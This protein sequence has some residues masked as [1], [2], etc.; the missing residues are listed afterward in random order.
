MQP[1]L[2]T[3]IKKHFTKLSLDTLNTLFA[4]KIAGIGSRKIAEELLGSKTK[5][6]TINYL[7]N[8]ILQ[9]R[10]YFWSINEYKK[11]S[12]RSQH[13]SN[14]PKILVLDIETAPILGCVWSLW[15]NNL[16][17]NQVKSDWFIMSFAAKW[18]GE[19]EESTIY[20]DVR[21]HIKDE[22]DSMLLETLWELL[23][24]ADF[25]LTQNGVKFDDKK[26]KARFVLNGFQPPSSYRHIDTLQIAKREFGF[27]SNKLEYMTD[28]L[29]KKYKKLKHGKFAGFELWRECMAE[30]PL[31]WDECEKYNRYDVLSLEELYTILA[32]WDRK[33]PN[34]NVYNISETPRCRCGSETF[35]KK[36]FVYTNLSKF[37]RYKCSECGA[38]SRGRN[39]L[40]DK[41]KRASLM[42]NLAA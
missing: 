11:F 5:K 13:D 19:P 39:N 20:Q 41:D 23:D 37:Q 32:P 8:S 40:L 27:T 4:K 21:G 18:F 24:Q 12:L 10:L 14:F 29:C 22:D 35:I 16:G 30:N 7:Y 38:E 25:V 36:G 6:S 15:N 31:A 3:E 1:K 2:D 17:L 34:F 42:G 26:I 28:K 33:H 9:D